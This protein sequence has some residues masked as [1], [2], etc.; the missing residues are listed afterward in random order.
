[1][2]CDGKNQIPIQNLAP[3]PLH[4]LKE[5]SVPSMEYLSVVDAHA[6][7]NV[8]SSA[9]ESPLLSQWHHLEEPPSMLLVK[10]CLL[11][12]PS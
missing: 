1:M 9:V 8:K 7:P 11:V 5:S 3:L 10:I 2:Q 4:T 12:W 6:I